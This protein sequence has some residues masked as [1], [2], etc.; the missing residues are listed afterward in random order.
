MSVLRFHTLLGYLLLN[1]LPHESNPLTH[2]DLY[3]RSDHVVSLSTGHQV[4]DG[5]TPG[6]HPDYIQLR[7]KKLEVQ[8]QVSADVKNDGSRILRN[9]RI[10]INGFLA[11]T[12]DIEMKRIITQAGG[13]VLMTP[14]GATHILTSQG[15]SGSKTHKLLTSKKPVHV[16]KPEWV[17]DSIDAGKRLSERPYN[18]IKSQ[19]S[20][21]LA[22]LWAEPNHKRT[23]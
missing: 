14:S 16:V 19:G 10:Y 21:T 8:R 20:G 13:Q 9:T 2:S 17:T 4:A 3:E 18:I 22:S 23:S 6:S 7:G 5:R 11:D 15:L 1:T 12:T